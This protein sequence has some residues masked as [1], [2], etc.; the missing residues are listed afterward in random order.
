[1]IINFFLPCSQYAKH[2][3]GVQ[4]TKNVF[5]WMFFGKQFHRS[6]RLVQNATGI[7][8]LTYTIKTHKRKRKHNWNVLRQSKNS[9]RIPKGT[10]Q[11]TNLIRPGE[12]RQLEIKMNIKRTTETSSRRSCLR[13]EDVQK[14]MV[15]PL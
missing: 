9:K 7:I 11:P 2:S 14:E 3:Q 4:R 15:R 1:M 13:L 8:S 5:Q 6:G 10:G 12:Q